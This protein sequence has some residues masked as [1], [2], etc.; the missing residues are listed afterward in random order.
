MG[1]VFFGGGCPKFWQPPAWGL[2]QPLGEPPRATCT[3]PSAAWGGPKKMGTQ[4]HG[5]GRCVGIRTLKNVWG[6]HGEQPQLPREGARHGPKATA[7]LPHPDTTAPLQMWGG[8]RGKRR[9]LGVP[10][11]TPRHPTAPQEEQLAA[12]WGCGAAVKVQLRFFA[13]GAM[14]TFPTWF[15]YGRLLPLQGGGAACSL[16]PRAR[17]GAHRNPQA[18]PGA[19]SSWHS[20]HQANIPPVA[21]HPT[22]GHGVQLDTEPA[23]PLVSDHQQLS[24]HGARPRPQIELRDGHTE[25]GWQT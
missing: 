4:P 5:T 1:C 8:D 17:T 2:H 7:P 12:P 24:S 18:A 9:E 15:N 25:P 21:T 16:L 22:R 19:G 6:A 13:R 23:E 14:A 10:H 3:V 20:C 11:S